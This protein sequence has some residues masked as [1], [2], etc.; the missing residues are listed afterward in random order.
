MTVRKRFA[1][2]FR[3]LHECIVNLL[4]WEIIHNAYTN[5]RNSDERNVALRSL[6]RSENKENI[7]KTLNLAIN[8]EVKDQDV[9]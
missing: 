8:G 4:Q 3:S 6:G 7:K 1:I 9:N 5:G 2:Y